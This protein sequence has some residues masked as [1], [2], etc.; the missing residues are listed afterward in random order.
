MKKETKKHKCPN[1]GKMW[2]CHEKNCRFDEMLCMK[3][4]NGE[5]R[6]KLGGKW[7]E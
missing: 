7:L 1:C 5:V 2:K 4:D 3:C 6:R